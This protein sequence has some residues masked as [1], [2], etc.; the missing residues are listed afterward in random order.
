M[1]AMIYGALRGGWWLDERKG[2]TVGAEERRGPP[3]HVQTTKVRE[4]NQL[5]DAGVI[6]ARCAYSGREDGMTGVQDVRW[7]GEEKELRY[8]RP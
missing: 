2:E 7:A 8:G 1:A 5:Y 4:K 3:G 6:W